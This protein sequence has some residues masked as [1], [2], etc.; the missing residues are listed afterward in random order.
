MMQNDLNCKNQKSGPLCGLRVLD[1]SRIL[2]GPYCTQLLGDFGADVVKVERAGEGD[3]TRSWGPP[4]VMGRNGEPIDA[5][6][7]FL[8]ANRNKRSIA[9]DIS[10]AEDA[11]LIRRMAAISDI[12]IENFK[13][14]GLCKYG[15]DYES[16]KAINPR[17]VYCSIT[18]FGQTGPN[19]E[20]PGYDLLAQA[21]GGIMS[22]TGEPDG[23]PMKVGVGVADVVCGLYAGNAI[24]AAIRHRDQT[25][26]GQHI[27][28]SL[29]D[30]QVSWLVNAGTN[31]LST[32]KLP[33]RLGNQHPN[34]VPYQL[35]A[36]ADGHVVVAVGNDAQYRRF[37][38]V[39]LR[40]DLAELPQFRTNDGRIANRET[41]ISLISE[42]L[43]KFN[44]ADLVSGLEAV[45]VPSGTVNNLE[46]V[47]ESDQ[48][49]ARGMKISMDY[50]ASADG[51]VHLIG[52]PVK[53]SQT[54]V[55]YRRPP[56][57]CGEH[58]HEILAELDRQSGALQMR[59]G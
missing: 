22:I 46:E 28:I 47:F 19:A 12:F 33:S 10:Q 35:F 15:L 52:N 48:V 53:F 5:S 38:E 24:L 59:Q 51:R 45:G 16:L 1:M 41:L 34:I 13:V 8:S 37:C 54:P 58:Q 3:D 9:L 18:G 42:E 43:L 36:V 50:P 21:F 57:G 4:Y 2:A 29:V 30:T 56:P 26:E 32:N 55:T 49:E 39:I 23:Q 31:F 20:K 6:A 14:G 7:Y 17:I 27:D 40:P 44:R 25:G 11:D